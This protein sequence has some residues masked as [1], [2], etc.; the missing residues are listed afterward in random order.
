MKGLKNFKILFRYFKND[1]LKLFLYII[2]TIAKYFEPLINA[3]VW[4]NAFQALATGNNYDFIKYLMCWSG[5]I[6]FM[7]VIIQVPT[8]L[9]YNYLEKKFMENVSKDLYTKVTNLPAIAFEE[10][11]V[12]EFINRMYTDPDRILEL[13]NKLIKLSCRLIIAIIIVGI[14]FSIS[15]Y[16][17]LELLVL[18]IVM[19][20]L[21]NIYYPKIKK[22]QEAIKKDS[23]EFIKVATQN[24]TGIREIKALGI[25]NNINRRI[26]VNVENLFKKQRKIGVDETF[27]YAL[28]NLC[29]FVIQ[30][31]ILLTLGISV[32]NGTIVLA[33][34]VVIEKYIWRI[35]E[36]VES[37]S[38]FGVSYNKVTVSLKRIDE[39]LNNILYEDEKFGQKKINNDKKIN[40]EFKNVSFKYRDEEEL[41]LNGLNL[42]LAPNKKIAIVGKSGQGK[43]TLFNLLLRYFDA[44]KGQILVNGEDIKNLSEESLRTNISVIRQSPY[45]FN[46]TIFDNFKIVKEDV[47]L[48]EIRS[49]CKKAYID[50][51]IMSL[52][53]GYETVIGEGGVNLS[54]GQKQR[55]AIARTLLKDTKVILFDEATSALD[56]ESQEYI[57]KT[58]DNLVKTHTIIIVAHRLS[59][60]MDADLIYVIDEGKVLNYGT[61]DELMSSSELYR[62]LYSPEVLDF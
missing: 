17:G 50:D 21:S 1:K 47:T 7:W 52:P 49:V 54:G 28:N 40:I 25:K 18:C 51:Y 48:E 32:F 59:T 46:S 31:I 23:D 6:I 2:L 15:I 4:A 45:L 8:D 30:F 29:Y 10:I 20:I 34:F 33:S 12:G 62:K 55:I 41:I 14:S 9:I 38:E 60:I 57:K 24:I 22:T 61:H 53:N 44:T 36:V 43:S 37:L 19:F 42:K 11:G 13:L 35:D 58:I 16:V 56:N 39:I 26:Y 5:L 3:F 27:Y